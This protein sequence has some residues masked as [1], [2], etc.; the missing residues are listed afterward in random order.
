[1]LNIISSKLMETLIMQKYRFPLSRVLPL[2]AEE[3]AG[4]EEE[5]RLLLELMFRSQ[6]RR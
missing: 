5:E 4:E 2:G 6:L 1:M 3:E